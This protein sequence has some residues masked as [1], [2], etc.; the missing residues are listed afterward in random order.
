MTMLE[1]LNDPDGNDVASWVAEATRLSELIWQP[2]RLIVAPIRHHSP[3]CARA[4]A[5]IIDQR[6]PAQ[7]LIE[8]PAEMTPLIPWLV[9]PETRAPVAVYLIGPRA[10]QQLPTSP[11]AV[12]GYLPLCDYSPELVALRRGTATGA[13][14]AFIDR[15]FGCRRPEPEHGAL[16]LMA[17]AH[18]RHGRFIQAL[19]DRIGARDADEVWDRLFEAA[20]DH[21]PARLFA[22]VGAYCLAIR[23]DWPE[24][25]LEADGTLARERTMA[26]A[27]RS[28]LAKGGEVLAVVGGF[29]AQAVATQALDSPPPPAETDAP[30]QAFLIRYS[31]D[32]LEALN[33]YT[34]G[35]PA[36][37][38]HQALWE[39]GP[40]LDQPPDRGTVATAFLGELAGWARSQIGPSL[41]ATPDMVAA[42][43][44][45]QSL[46]ELRGHCA[47]Q[48]TELTDAV[49]SAWVKGN[50]EEDGRML[51][52]ELCRLMTGDRLGD[53]PAG[54]GHPPLVAEARHRAAT[55]GFEVT[56]TTPRR[57]ALEIY[58]KPKDRARSRFLHAMAYLDTGFA[59]FRA[60]PDLIGNRNLDRVI[61]HWDCAWTPVVE[62][63][64]V[65]AAR[66]G[67]TVDEAC[68]ARVKAAVAA[69]ERNP[70]AGGSAKAVEL[71]TSLC[72][73]GLSASLPQIV[74]LVAGQIRGDNDIA[75]LVRAAAGLTLLWSGRAHLAGVERGEIEPLIVTAFHRARWLL[76]SASGRV[77]DPARALAGAL[78]ELQELLLGPWTRLPGLT[79]TALADA[80]ETV[81]NG[82]GSGAL[83]RGAA[84]G[85]LAGTGRIDEP[86]LARALAGWLTG[87]AGSDQV[88][89]VQGLV[90]VRRG[91]LW[92]SPEVVAAL[93]DWMRGLEEE[94]FLAQLPEVRLAFLP[95]S[96]H[97][98]A[99]LAEALVRRI[100]GPVLPGS[101]P[102]RLTTEDIVLGARL[103]SVLAAS[104]AADGLN[105]WGPT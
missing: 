35:M 25:L 66:W 76:P 74:S 70:G 73:I 92:T 8:G 42:L 69:L 16:S 71:L 94:V 56:T 10:N 20:D 24:A 48:R 5:A 95:L 18:W 87:A 89:V 30:G 44:Q 27:I 32:R 58:R 23:R 81:W 13:K 91:A 88:L 103:A 68:L 2:G 53:I 96:A 86:G 12:A 34:A 85:L 67:G 104:R 61:E 101:S 40:A 83:L 1:G 105:E 17:E 97:E 65:E 80:A 93:D 99:A 102:A 77:G 21:D 79:V 29:H 36:P 43:T 37:A 59:V 47:I 7:I 72:L 3:A 62:G 41:V 49:G 64:L 11:F 33:G 82:A 60:G 9:H 75:S 100:G 84:L 19:T 63:R 78:A 15:G 55:L 39:S 50:R 28:A 26:A 6:R 90:L 31:F 46:A 4:V 57:I 98:V 22:Q 45:A 54:A 38:W 52:S 51:L 14:L